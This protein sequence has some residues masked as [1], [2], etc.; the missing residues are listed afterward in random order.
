[1]KIKQ[2]FV[3]Q[4]VAGSYL[5]C[6]TGALAAEFSGVVRMNATG[7]FIFEILSRGAEKEEI[8]DK[9]VSEYGISRDIAERDVTAYITYLREN[10][11]IEE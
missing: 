1:M 2:G 10:G 9:V 5:A 8:I 3:L 4:N 7:A 6:A 11:V